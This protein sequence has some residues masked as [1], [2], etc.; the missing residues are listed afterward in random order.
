MRLL[1]VVDMQNDFVTGALGTP[2]ARGIV[3]LVKAKIQE[4]RNAGDEIIFT[5][6]THSTNYLSTHEGQLLPVPHCI[7]NTDGWNL[8][9][10]IEC[11]RKEY[12]V[13]KHTFGFDEWPDF[14]EI[15]YWSCPDEIEIIGLCTDI[16]VV[17]NALILRANYPKADII[18]DARCC[19]GTT[20][21]KHEAALQVMESCQIEVKR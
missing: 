6:D 17:S 8:V 4:Y 21:Q 1:I 16:C 3:E 20:P 13:I 5:M 10:G 18:V 2:E 9:S 11:G 14:I 15:H 12:Y 7:I 19:A